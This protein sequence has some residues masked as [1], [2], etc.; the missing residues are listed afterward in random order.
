M[1]LSDGE[2]L[3]AFLPNRQGERVFSGIGPG[4]QVF[5]SWLPES[6]WVVADA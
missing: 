5:A 4:D 1:K 2:P 6:N 3:L